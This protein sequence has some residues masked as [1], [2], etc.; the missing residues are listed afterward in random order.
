MYKKTFLVVLGAVIILSA[1]KTASFYAKKAEKHYTEGRYEFAIQNYQQ[2]LEKGAPKAEM[3]FKIAESYRLSNRLAASKPYYKDALDNGISDQSA[4]FYY[5][6]SLKANGEYESAKDYLSAYVKT[7]KDRRYQKLAQYEAKK[8]DMIQDL[9]FVKWSY[10]VK[11]AGKLNSDAEDYSPVMMGEDIV[12]A[13]SRGEGELYGGNGY[14]FSD[15]YVASGE[16]ISKLDETG[17]INTINRHEASPTFSPDGNMM[18]FARSNAGE[19]KEESPDVDLYMSTKSETGNWSAPERLNINTSSD[20]DGSPMFSPDGKYLY[21][22]S[23]R[24][25]GRGG[26]DLWRASYKDGQFAKP[27]NLGKAYNTFGNEMFPFIHED[28]SFYFASDGHVGYGGLDL[29][30]MEMDRVTKKMGTKPAN[31]GKSINTVSDDFGIT[32]T[33]RLNGYFV[34]NREGGMGGDDIYMFEKEIIPFYF[35]DLEVTGTKNNQKLTLDNASITFVEDQNKGENAFSNEKGHFKHQLHKDG[36]YEIRVEKDSFFTASLVFNLDKAEIEKNEKNEDG[37]YIIKEYINLKKLG[38][39][40]T[41]DIKELS[42]DI[43]D[44]LYD[45]SSA[46]I[47]EDAAKELDKLAIFLKENPGITIELGS[48]TDSRDS[49]ANNF[50]LSTRRA[51]SAVNYIVENGGVEKDRITSKGYGE[52]KLLNKCKDGVNCGEE[53]HQANR[54]TE[55]KILNVKNVNAE[56]FEQYKKE[57]ELAKIKA[58]EAEKQHQM[59][60]EYVM[61]EEFEEEIAEF[62]EAGIKEG[63]DEY[64]DYLKKKVRLNELKDHFHEMELELEK[65]REENQLEGAKE[66]GKKE[67]VKEE[68]KEETST[69]EDEYKKYLEMKRKYEEMEQKMKDA[70]DKEGDE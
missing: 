5:G 37:D 1:C 14:G 19:K 28:G 44:I 20:W 27:Q 33:D 9:P 67:A 30:V 55:I 61:I 11:N 43:N 24:K 42:P 59:E 25:G 18:V 40:E 48:H 36:H 65:F 29:F 6:M 12:F 15:L 58:E 57:Q 52:S 63:D 56:K 66:E 31:L 4:Y 47:R 26:L 39:K 62:E 64:T 68:K 70:E 53:E 54:R 50:L 23:D 60:E 38:E 69:E 35:L 46:E 2:A 16:T 22:V 3:N 21:F 45:L 7:S 10:T 41:Y 17:V 32:F 13:S 51:E 49:E 34:S 8:I